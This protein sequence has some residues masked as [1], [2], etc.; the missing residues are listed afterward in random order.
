MG[1]LKIV[2][3]NNIEC[4]GAN[5]SFSL[6]VSLCAACCGF[7]AVFASCAVLHIIT[8]EKDD[9]RH[10]MP[11]KMAI[12]QC[13]LDIFSGFAMVFYSL[14][15]IDYVDSF[16]WLCACASIWNFTFI[17]GRMRF[18]LARPDE[19]LRYRH[20]DVNARIYVG[21]FMCFL[22][23]SMVVC[24]LEV[25]DD[26]LFY[27]QLAFGS[28][29]GNIGS[30][31]IHFFIILL[32]PFT[33]TVYYLKRIAQI[34]SRKKIITHDT[35]TKTKKGGSGADFDSNVTVAIF[36]L[37]LLLATGSRWVYILFKPLTYQTVLSHQSLLG[38]TILAGGVKAVANPAMIWQ[39]SEFCASEGSFKEDFDEVP[40]E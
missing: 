12:C 4:S 23:S 6:T 24:S 40:K 22:T 37:I 15:L 35:N 38:M 19:A 9:I 39:L 32:A 13:L 36:C 21:V 17:L 16:F 33:L 11:I 25:E 5:D 18:V 29:A 31:I 34:Y 1:I 26:S 7:I 14:G 20:W 28:V 10:D 30:A 2:S 8:R 3:S 27:C